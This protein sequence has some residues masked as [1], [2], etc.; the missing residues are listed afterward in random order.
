MIQTPDEARMRIRELEVALKRA[1]GE[2][3][4]VRDLLTDRGLTSH[5]LNNALKLAQA[6]LAQAKEGE[7]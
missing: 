7:R 6:A 1:A 2:M 4:A 5:R 3:R